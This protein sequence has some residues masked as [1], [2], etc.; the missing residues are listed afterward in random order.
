MHANSIEIFLKSIEFQVIGA[1]SAYLRRQLDMINCVDVITL[2]ETF[3][4]PRLRRF[5]YNFISENFM[6][7]SR[8]QLNRLTLE[9]V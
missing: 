7:L 3:T 6:T 2:S 4:L 9:Q 1:C 8:Q 5:A